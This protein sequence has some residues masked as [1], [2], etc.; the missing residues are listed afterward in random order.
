MKMTGTWDSTMSMIPKGGNT[1]WGGLDW[2]LEESC[3]LHTRKQSSNN[4]Q[5]T[6]QK[7]NKTNVN[8]GRMIQSCRRGRFV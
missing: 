2:S 7:T 8:Y 1:I 3:G 5:L 6:K 4:T